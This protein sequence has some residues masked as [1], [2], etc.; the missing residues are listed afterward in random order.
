VKG[1]AKPST[2]K[3]DLANVEPDQKGGESGGIEGGK[4][5]PVATWAGVGALEGGLVESAIKY[6]KGAAEDIE[7]I[8]GVVGGALKGIAVVAGAIATY[9]ATKELIEHPTIGNGLKVAGN[10]AITIL[11]S[12]SRLNPLVGV[13]LTILDLTGATDAIYKGL[14]KV[15]GDK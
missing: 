9:Q 15:F 1:D 13:G 2:T 6:G 11:A 10:L 8:E 14:G 3:V 7:P 12:A 4:L 5:N